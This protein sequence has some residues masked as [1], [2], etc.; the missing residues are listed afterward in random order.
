MQN[1]LISRIELVNN[2]WLVLAYKQYRESSNSEISKTDT[3]IYSEILFVNIDKHKSAIVIFVTIIYNQL[4]FADKLCYL[5]LLYTN[6][7]VMSI[8]NAILPGENCCR[9][10]MT[11][12]Y[13][14][15]EKSQGYPTNKP[16]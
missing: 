16:S 13:E 11:P 1:E 12:V 4:S 2:I 9:F 10:S 3:I 7:N 6:I 15:Y 5:F 14:F 8:N